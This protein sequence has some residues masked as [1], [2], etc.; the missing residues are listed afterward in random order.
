MNADS[1]TQRTEFNIIKGKCTKVAKIVF[2]LA[3]V[4]S[5]HVRNPV[6]AVQIKA[7]IKGGLL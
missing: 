5:T 3:C 7:M 6:Q 1:D 4:P 2:S